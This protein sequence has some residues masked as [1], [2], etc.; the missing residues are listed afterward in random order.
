MKRRVVEEPWLLARAHSAKTNEASGLTALSPEQPA[1]RCLP[2]SSSLR[3][4]LGLVLSGAIT[5]RNHTIALR[6]SRPRLNQYRLKIKD[7]G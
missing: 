6:E 4:S 5:G 1:V 7:A 3:A 2:A